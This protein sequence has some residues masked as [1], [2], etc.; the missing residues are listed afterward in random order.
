M[1][2]LAGLKRTPIRIHND[3]TSTVPD[4][5]AVDGAFALCTQL[6][7]PRDCV[8]DRNPES[9]HRHAHD[10]TGS[11]EIARIPETPAVKRRR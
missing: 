8:S 3:Q 6:F 7:G 4:L 5:E 9:Q 1:S 10:L 11:D 2:A